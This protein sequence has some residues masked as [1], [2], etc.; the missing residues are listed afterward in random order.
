MVIDDRDLLAYADGQLAPERRAE[1]EAAIASSADVAGQVNAMRASALPYAAAFEAQILPPMP[2]ELSDR[3]AALVSADSRG[4]QRGQSAWP[5]LAT[6]FAAGVL[7]CAIA[8][9]LLSSGVTGFSAT[10]QV[11]PWIRAVADYQ[12]LY[13]RATVTHVTEDPQ[14]SARVISDLWTADGIRVVVPDL[15][16]AGLNFKRVQRLSFREQPVVQMVYLPE[17]GEPVAL[18]VTLDAR[19]DEKPRA[20]QIGELSTVA[21][22]DGELGYVLL[23][24]APAQALMDL[25]SRIAKGQT[26]SLYGA[27]AARQPATPHKN[28]DSPSAPARPPGIQAF[29]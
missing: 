17:Q 27:P 24:K 22:R 1:I 19:P 2:R 15:R 28:D 26:N 5:R 25:G 7:C 23:G 13:S 9:K 8:L 16:I 14:L 29:A 6:A 10:A 4:R 11:E 18:C 3:I 12:Q 21:W 20:Q